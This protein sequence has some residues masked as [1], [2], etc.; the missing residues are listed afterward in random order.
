MAGQIDDQDP[1]VARDGGVHRRVELPDPDGEQ[2]ARGRGQAEQAPG[3][4]QPGHQHQDAG[5]AQ[6]PDAPHQ[7]APQA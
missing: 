3:V 7:V 5:R 1:R 2:T 6:V 4:V